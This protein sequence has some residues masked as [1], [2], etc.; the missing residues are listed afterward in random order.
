MA[1]PEQKH[2]EYLKHRDS[3]IAR[4][5]AWRVEN[6]ERLKAYE[7]KRY[8]Q[9]TDRK[10]KT[11]ARTAKRRKANPDIKRRDDNKYRAEHK[12]EIAAYNQKY[13]KEHPEVQRQNN[14]RRR[15]K[16][17]GSEPSMKINGAKIFEACKWKCGICGQKV[18][19]KLKHPD[20]MSASL[21]HIV[22]LSRDGKHEPSNC[23]LA[24][25]GCNKKKNKSAAPYGLQIVLPLTA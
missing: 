5:K 9:N 1:T 24:H 19:K 7:R 10:A 15:A 6:A 11:I 17:Y 16:M 22:P 14:H 13:F 12:Q 25:L 18:D 21:D 20:P 23:Q 8:L 2:T 4:A 3:Y